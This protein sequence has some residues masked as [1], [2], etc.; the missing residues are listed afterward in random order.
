MDIRIYENI[1]RIY[2]R[3][4]YMALRCLWRVFKGK[5]KERLFQLLCDGSNRYYK[6]GC[7]YAGP[8]GVLK[9]RAGCRHIL[10]DFPGGCPEKAL[11]PKIA[12]RQL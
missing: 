12:G 10:R 11:A 3:N 8:F 5:I 2:I 9:Y 7:P 1:G 6:Y 4:V